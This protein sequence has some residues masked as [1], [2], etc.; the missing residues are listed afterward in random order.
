MIQIIRSSERYTAR[1]GW[2]TSRFSF[3]FAQYQDPNNT[4]FGPLRVFNDDTVDPGAGFDLHPHRDME[5]VSIVLEGELEHRDS[6]GNTGR[7]KAGEVQRITAGTGVLHSEYNASSVDPV[8]FLQIWFLPERNGLPPSW[9]QSAFPRDGRINRLQLVVTGKTRPPALTIR[10]DASVY[11]CDLEPGRRVSHETDPNRKLY[12]F[13]VRGAL[14]LDLPSGPQRL[15]HGDSG[16][17]EQESG[18]TVSSPDG[19]E[20]LLMDL[21]H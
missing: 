8:H 5:I 18:L 14:D 7:I 9:E 10:Q 1:H 4:R 12:L 21:A 20:F 17:I 6:M 3:S 13:V 16:R 11:R 2:L 19:A 15:E